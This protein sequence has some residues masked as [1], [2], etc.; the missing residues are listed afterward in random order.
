DRCSVRPRPRGPAGTADPDHGEAAE[1][2][3]APSVEGGRRGGRGGGRQA[4]RG[5]APLLMGSGGAGPQA[6]LTGTL[7][8]T[9]MPAVTSPVI[10]PSSWTP[11]SSPKTP[12]D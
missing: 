4:G 6:D 9:V 10:V 11:P 3:A 12:S 7:S 8:V 1:G 5:A 2:P